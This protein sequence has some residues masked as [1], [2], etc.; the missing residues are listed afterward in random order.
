MPPEPI[1]FRLRVL[2]ALTDALKTIVRDGEGPY[3]YDMAEAVFRG[4]DLFGDSDPLPMLSILEDPNPPEQIMGQ[5]N[6]ALSRG[7]WG[8][9]IQGFMLDDTDNPTDPGHYLLADVKT[10]LAAEAR[11]DQG[12]NILGMSGKVTELLWGGGTVRPADEHVSAR[13]YFWLPVTL[14]LAENHN[15]PFA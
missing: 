9:L 12:F 8:L 3:G 10:V 2:I 7:G 14:G 4:R 11:R 15:E 6:P 5:A 13:A 1:P